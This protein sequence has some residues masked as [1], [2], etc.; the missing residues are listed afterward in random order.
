MGCFG[1][2]FTTGNPERK[3]T[4]VY[5]FDQREDGDKMMPGLMLRWETVQEQWP[6]KVVEVF[7]LGREV[8][9]PDFGKKWTE[10]KDW[11]QARLR[12]KDH[13][14]FIHTNYRSYSAIFLLTSD[15]VQEVKKEGKLV[16]QIEM[17]PQE[18][19]TSIA[20]V[21]TSIPL[22]STSIGVGPKN[23]SSSKRD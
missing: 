18:V 21:S 6:E 17:D 10:D 14:D 13:K 20:L 22:V 2:A 8:R 23:P 5:T 7:E 4:F 11:G 9:S 3:I 16:V 12:H 15:V 19:S 1:D